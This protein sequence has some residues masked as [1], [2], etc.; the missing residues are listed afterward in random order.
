M[1]IEKKE[2]DEVR[3]VKLGKKTD[4]WESVCKN[5]GFIPLGFESMKIMCTSWNEEK[6]DALEADLRLRYPNK[7]TSTEFY[8]IIKEFYT[9]GSDGKTILWITEVD[10][11]LHWGI[12]SGNPVIEKRDIAPDKEDVKT[13][14]FRKLED[15]WKSCA[16]NEKGGKFHWE[17]IHGTIGKTHRSQQSIHKI[18]GDPQKV[19]AYLKKLINGDFT[20]SE[21]TKALL[22]AL[23][24]HKFEAFIANVMMMS[25]YLI[26]T[27]I[28]RT[29]KGI[30]FV[31]SP[32]DELAFKIGIQIKV[33]TDKDEAQECKSL[34]ESYNKAWYIYKDA[35]NKMPESSD[36]IKYIQ[37]DSHWAWLQNLGLNLDET[38]KKCLANWLKE[39]V[40]F[41]VFE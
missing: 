18:G 30:D 13:V 16:T 27:V 9:L 3:F 22:E 36:N 20:H 31:I 11:L 32:K 15:G 37:V 21:D 6:K 19:N 28:G 26:T 1:S 14:Y 34:L 38:Q 33:K 40:R 29:Q 23:S 8:N 24:P 4:N 7:S 10:N 12:T 39:Q 25:G 41:G 35:T 2:F 17:D 5:E